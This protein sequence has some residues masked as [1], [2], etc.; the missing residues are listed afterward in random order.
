MK[1]EN[2][3][4]ALRYITMVQ[5]GEI[6]LNKGMQHIPSLFYE[7]FK[8]EKLESSCGIQFPPPKFVGVQ[9]PTPPPAVQLPPPQ[10]YA[11]TPEE[12]TKYGE[13]F[14]TYDTSNVGSGVVVLLSSHIAVSS[15]RVF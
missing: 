6:P 4:T 3:F 15:H 8:L 9:L 5:N 11:M 1:K 14:K 7:N 10:A 13:L 12:I 2:F